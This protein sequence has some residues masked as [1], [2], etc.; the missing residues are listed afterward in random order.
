MLCV[1]AANILNAKIV[2]DE[3]KYDGSPSVA[4]EAGCSWSLVVSV[5]VKAGCEQIVG[6]LTGLF[7]TVY[8]FLYLEVYPAIAGQGAEVIFVG[9]F[10]WYDGELYL[11]VFMSV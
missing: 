3:G 11:Y 5:L 9:E 8:P 1:L 6:Q 10:L 4:P 2:N 7:K